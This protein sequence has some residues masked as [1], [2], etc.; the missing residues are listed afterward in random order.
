MWDNINTIGNRFL[1]SPD[2]MTDMKVNRNLILEDQFAMS[3]ISGKVVKIDFIEDNEQ[4]AEFH[5]L[6]IIPYN[7]L[8]L[9][10]KLNRSHRAN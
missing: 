6:L 3:F 9:S 8:N 10:F 5:F 1:G 7:I 2:R 4:R